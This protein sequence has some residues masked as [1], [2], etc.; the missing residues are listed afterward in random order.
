MHHCKRHKPAAR[1]RRQASRAKHQGLVAAFG[2]LAAMLGVL[3]A[4]PGPAQAD[5]SYAQAMT[6]SEEA[7]TATTTDDGTAWVDYGS[8]K[9]GGPLG[10]PVKSTVSYTAISDWM[11]VGD[12][13]TVRSY[14]ELLPL[15][16][17]KRLAVDAWSGRNTQLA[18]DSVLDTLAQVGPENF[19]KR[20][21]WFTGS[22]D[23]FAPGVVRAQL[24]RLYA[25]LPSDVQVWFVDTQVARPSFPADQRNCMWVN[26]QITQVATA[27]GA[28]IISW[29]TFLASKPSRLGM[30]IDAGGVHPT[31]P[32]EEKPNSGTK[33]LAALIAG[34]VWPA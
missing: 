28:K 7:F 15:T 24:E 13:I 20:L 32:T 17:G 9:P 14:K 25:A 23:V 18:V 21:V 34:A 4:A 19:P 3:Y 22:N 16:I 2:I 10:S 27:H 30:Y 6:T 1:H 33:A 29:A 8:G 5:T 31:L 26:S 11:I 12:S